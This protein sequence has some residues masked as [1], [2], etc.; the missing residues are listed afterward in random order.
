MPKGRK[1]K[2]KKKKKSKW[3]PR[4]TS[5]KKKKESKKES[6]GDP[7]KDF[8]D[9]VEEAALRE[10]EK[11]KI[12]DAIVETGIWGNT[13]RINVIYSK[14]KENYTLCTGATI[15]G[16]STKTPPANWNA[17]AARDAYYTK[18]KNRINSWIGSED[19]LAASCWIGGGASSWDTTSS[20]EGSLSVNMELKSA[21]GFKKLQDLEETLKQGPKNLYDSP[22]NSSTKE[23]IATITGVRLKTR[24]KPYLSLEDTKQVFR[25]VANLEPAVDPEGERVC[26]ISSYD[27]VLTDQPTL[28]AKCRSTIKRGRR[29]EQ[30]A[31]PKSGYEQE[32]CPLKDTT[33]KHR[34]FK[35]PFVSRHPASLSAHTSFQ[36]DPTDFLPNPTRRQTLYELIIARDE[37]KINMH[38]FKTWAPERFGRYSSEK[39]RFSRD[40][41]RQERE[42]KTKADKNWQL[43]RLITAHKPNSILRQLLAE[44]DLDTIKFA[45]SL[46]KI[47]KTVMATFR[48]GHGHI[49]EVLSLMGRFEVLT[50]LVDEF[51]LQPRFGPEGNTPVTVTASYGKIS[52]LKGALDAFPKLVDTGD[53][54]RRT[55]LQY[56]VMSNSKEMINL[57]LERRADVNAQGWHGDNALALACTKPN[58]DATT[59]G[60]VAKLLSRGATPQKGAAVNHGGS[61]PPTVLPKMPPPPMSEDE[62]LASAE[63]D[64]VLASP[65]ED[66]VL[67]S[68]EEDEVLETP[69]KAQPQTPRKPRGRPGVVPQRRSKRTPAAAP[70]RLNL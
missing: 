40:Y 12:G 30:W 18:I 26:L 27:M 33:L 52:L 55:P 57:L 7:P 5:A 32:Y 16:I 44:A 62:V 65:E 66:E 69:H 15:T 13:N 23:L 19:V 51:G 39:P 28:W 29:T 50:M 70:D 58:P 47:P 14:E 67:A 64:E 2:K 48:M 25:D 43:L 9:F 1:G 3:G 54:N 8:K 4:K 63:E 46:F 6:E 61:L 17:Y 59:L 21:Q 22:S 10:K 35:L 11:L 34:V 56:A 41:F 49:F 45:L 53:Y 24:S 38:A 68:A 60:T 31:T 37:R 42:F 36:I 20:R